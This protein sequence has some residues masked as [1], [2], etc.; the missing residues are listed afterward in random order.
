[1]PRKRKPD[2]SKGIRPGI[3]YG[4]TA[5]RTPTGVYKGISHAELVD[6]MVAV[7]VLRKED[8]DHFTKPGYNRPPEGCVDQAREVFE[9]FGYQ[10]DDEDWPYLAHVAWRL[11]KLGPCA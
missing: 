8:P 3:R 11:D 5:R 9:H 6:L 10:T 7:D 4:R 2:R 1:M